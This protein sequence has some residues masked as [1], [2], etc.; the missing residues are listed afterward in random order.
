MSLFL[1]GSKSHAGAGA[2]A[3]YLCARLVEGLDQDRVNFVKDP[4]EPLVLGDDHLPLGLELPDGD[5]LLLGLLLTVRAAAAHAGSAVVLQ[6]LV[7][8]EEKVPMNEKCYRKRR[9]LSAAL[10]FQRNYIYKEV[11][12]KEK[13]S[14]YGTKGSVP[15]KSKCK[16]FPNWP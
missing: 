12:Q 1:W 5:G 16:L 2:G 10:G 15:K 11:S 7:Y 6:E 8:E 14:F 4:A 13:F 3:G 9:S